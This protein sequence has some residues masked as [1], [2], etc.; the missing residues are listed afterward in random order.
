MDLGLQE[1]KALVMGASSGLGKAVAQ[2]LISEGASAVICARGRDRLEATAEEIGARP[3]AC[4]LSRPGAAARLVEEAREALGGLDILVSNTGGPPQGG[5]LDLDARDWEEGFHG[6]W[7]S[8][9]ESMKAA[10]PSMQDQGWGRLLLVTSVAAREPVAGLTISNAYRAGLHGLVNTVSREA[11]PHG[12][13][14]NALMPGYTKTERLAE[15]GVSDDD[16][17][18]KIPARRLGRPD[19]FGALAAFLASEKAAYI[20]GQ[21]IAVD[22]GLL[23]S[24]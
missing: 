23:Q 3:I 2:A 12:V 17:S 18:A 10:L 16:L 21:A 15:L 7:M 4:D 6:L 13:T 20:T 1:K 14:V 11:A 22:G 8:A 5:F 9:V 24:I 19:E